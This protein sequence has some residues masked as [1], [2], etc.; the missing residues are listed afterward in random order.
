MRIS[1]YGTDNS[2]KWGF[3]IC[4][5]SL[6]GVASN[7]PI[8]VWQA[9]TRLMNPTVPQRVIDEAMERDP[10][11]A[12]SEF[13]AQFRTDVAA[14]ISRNALMA[15]V[16]AGVYSVPRR[17]ASATTLLS[18]RAVAPATASPWPLVTNWA[19]SPCWIAFARY[20]PRFRPNRWSA[21]LPCV[22]PVGAVHVT[23]GHN[24]THGLRAAEVCDLRW[25]QID[26]TGAVL[27]VRRVKN[28]I[29]QHRPD[30]A[31]RQLHGRPV[32]A[33]RLRQRTQVAVHDGG[34]CPA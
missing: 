26:F 11:S 9:P 1:T 15:C 13:M 17:R 5:D 18:I 21:N 34:L 27:H 30:P 10:A 3:H 4:D 25:D 20:V 16:S 8:L 28:G 23:A 29:T 2:S 33:H 6:P 14:W 24:A 7:D 32:V 22:R 12:S 31:L 19:R